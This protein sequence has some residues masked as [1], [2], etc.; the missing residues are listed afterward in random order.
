MA[1]QQFVDVKGNTMFYDPDAG[2]VFSEGGNR[3]TFY[4]TPEEWNARQSNVVQ[5]QNDTQVSSLSSTISALDKEVAKRDK[6]YSEA[7]SLVNDNPFYS[8][9]TR[10][11]KQ[12]KVDEKYQ[13]DKGNLINQRATYQQ[14]LEA[15]NTQQKDAADQAFKEKVASQ[16]VLQTFK[17]SAGNTISVGIDP[18]TNRVVSQT[19]LGGGSTGSSVNDILNR[20][21]TPNQSTQQYQSKP[22]YQSVQPTYGPPAPNRVQTPQPTAQPQ[23][24]QGGF[25]QNLGKAFIDP[26]L[27]YGKFALEAANQGVIAAQNINPFSEQS[28]LRDKVVNLTAT[29]EES[30][31]YLQL[32]SPQF[33]NQQELGKFSNP[34]SGAIQTGKYAAGAASYLPFGGAGI[35]GAA[36]S[37][38]LG[39]G[40]SEVSRDDAT[41]G[42]VAG[43]AGIGGVTGGILAGASSLISKG[44]SKIFGGVSGKAAQSINKATPTQFANVVEQLGIDPNTLTRKYVPAGAGYDDLLGPIVQ[45]NKG[46]I[47]NTTLDDAEK[48]IQSTIKT[49]GRGQ[50]AVKVSAD[51]FIKVLKQER[52]E[53]AKIPGNT[54][55]IKALDTF[56]KDTQ[57]LYKNGI[58]ASKLLDIKRA[59]DSK[60]G[61]AV[62][63]ENVGSVAAQ[64]QKMLANASRVKLKELFP[65][66]ADALET[67]S[68]IL[69]FRPI[70]ARARGTSNTLGSDIRV[71]DISKVN[72]LNPLTYGKGVD[73]AL[74][75]PNVASRALNAEGVQLPSGAGTAANVG[76]AASA[77][78][79]ILPSQGQPA[80]LQPPVEQ[81][82]P[83]QAVQGPLAAQGLTPDTLANAIAMDQME[84]GGQNYQELK[85][86]YDLAV[87]E[88]KRTADTESSN[89]GKAAA[90]DVYTSQS[91]LRSLEALD[92]LIKSDPGKVFAS[93]IPGAIGARDYQAAAYDVKDAIARLRT[94]AAMTK[95]EEAY[96]ENFLPQPLDSPEVQAQKIQRLKEYFSSFAGSQAEAGY[97]PAPNGGL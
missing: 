63:D 54:A 20:A 45:K 40:L 84:T 66:I 29:P 56:I 55:N 12:A 83:E 32:T 60:F 82:A 1:K 8:E 30:S 90:K 27:N 18:Y 77:V 9:G 35:A 94:G 74:A 51:D 69:T 15:F 78:N 11:G 71:G 58:T 21:R 37:G 6:A 96:Y 81:Q 65:E 41:V 95:Q 5:K 43:A 3:D 14:Q 4:R 46:G 50:S 91:G 16:P 39:G 17:D 62:V 10:V 75:N 70:L 44:V 64:G 86:L 85:R 25:L 61:A 88:E 19:N 67:Q 34:V 13:I 23:A 22:Q 73:A 42:S 89:V 76:R 38:I 31:R 28:K 48:I 59:A 49:A 7:I 93:N 87:D 97:I 57:K 92:T 52:K 80:P 68:E 47:L 24:N 33:L 2:K 53:L 79:S 72:P 36:R 26:A